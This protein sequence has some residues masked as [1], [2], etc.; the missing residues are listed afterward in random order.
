MM[1][2]FL[3]N[4]TILITGHTGFKGTWLSLL[5]Y[6]LGGKVIGISKDNKNNKVFHNSVKKLNFKNYYFDLRNYKKLEKVL[7]VHKP[8]FIFHLAAQALVQDSYSDPYDTFHNNFI[9]S[10]NLLEICRKK[11]ISTNLIFITSD[12]SYKN[13]EKK[14]GYK[15]TDTLGGEDPYSGS[16]ASLE[17]LINS[18]TK[19]FFMNNKKN[20]TKIAVAR[21]GNV[22]GGSD[23]SKNRIIPDAY[24]KWHIGKKLFLRNP[25][26]TRPWQFVLE[27]LFGYLLL[28]KKL[29]HNQ[30]IGECFNF[31]PKYSKHISTEE[32]IKKLNKLSINLVPNNFFYVKKTKGKYNFRESNLLQL[33]SKKAYRSLGWYCILNIEQTLKYTAKW[34]I[35]FYSSKNILKFTLN[36]IEDYL[37]EFK[38]STIK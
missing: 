3:K 4:K 28:A 12:K 29:L 25:S 27:P 35:M 33:N 19:S 15:E 23:L 7:I 10:L 1:F 6:R 32:L 8:K 30:Y 26:S 36:Q 37:N 38:T 24:K 20:K 9:S 11:N 2:D 13:V 22:I 5:C 31:G 21:A 18:Y 17:M 16:K 14:M 34:Y